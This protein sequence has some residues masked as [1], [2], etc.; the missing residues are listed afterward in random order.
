M[1]LSSGCCTYPDR[2][3]VCFKSS[4]TNRKS[5][6]SRLLYLLTAKKYSGL[7]PR[8]PSPGDRCGEF[9]VEVCCFVYENGLLFA[10][11]SVSLSKVNRGPSED[12]VVHI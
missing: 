2:V 3:F 1:T 5:A 12:A 8:K 10:V 7:L 6:Y 9:Q 11:Y 4:Q